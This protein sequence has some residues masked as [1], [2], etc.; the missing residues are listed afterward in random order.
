MDEKMSEP[1]NNPLPITNYQW[2]VDM[3]MGEIKATM[4]GLIYCLMLLDI[5]MVWL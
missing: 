4:D 3:R 2:M 5:L 1:I